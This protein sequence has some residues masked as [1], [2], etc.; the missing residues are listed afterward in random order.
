[1]IATIVLGIALVIAV[2][3]IHFE[4]L[5]S[6]GRFAFS[7]AVLARWHLI[8]V[9]LLI[10]CLHLVEICV[11]SAG[12]YLAHHVF[13]LGDFAG[14]REFAMIDYFHFS[15]ETFTT[16]GYGDLYPVGPLRI[17]SSLESIAGVL[18]ITWSGAFSYFTVQR[19]WDSKPKNP[20]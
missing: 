19:L 20:A 9:I 6:I 1:M 2:V 10:M 3:L 4:G 16:V 18:L 13:H 14:V 17:L 8:C 5:T 12:M 7:G 11:F 15:A